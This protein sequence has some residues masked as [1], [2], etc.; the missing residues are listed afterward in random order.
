MIFSDLA[1]QTDQAGTKTLQ[2]MLKSIIIKLNYSLGASRCLNLLQG[3]RSYVRGVREPGISKRLKLFSDDFVDNDELVNDPEIL[4]TES[5]FMNVG[6][7]HKQFEQEEKQFKNK[8]SRLVVGQKY[9]KET[10]VNFLTWSEKEQIRILNQENPREW[11]PDKLSESFPADPLTISKIVRNRW[12][13]KDENRIAKHDES[14]KKSWAKFKT[15]EL[16]VDP[17]LAQHLKRF[18]HRDFKEVSRQKV[19]RKLGVDIPKP[20]KTEFLSIITTCKKY[21]QN[22]ES[23]KQQREMLRLEQPNE[24]EMEFPKWRPKNPEQDSI[25]MT[26]KISNTMAMM[27]LREYQKHSPEIDL[28]ETRRDLAQPPKPVRD[29]TNV[30]KHKESSVATLHINDKKVFQSLEIQEHITIPKKA[31]IEGKTYKVDDCFYDDDGEFLYRV[32]GLK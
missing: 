26:S 15:G 7:A 4:E 20:A 5:D 16:E 8:L 30:T 19:K 1:G 13:P 32:P 11:S 9:F 14:V 31:W 23:E 3:S 12:Q 21:S 29:L 17:L 27:P 6:E 10:A 18:A 22:D 28:T 2:N 24:D 25:V